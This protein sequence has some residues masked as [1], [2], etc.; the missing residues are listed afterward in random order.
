[1]KLTAEQQALVTDN[2]NFAYYLAHKWANQ[3]RVIDRDDTTCI[4]C[5]ALCRAALLFDPDRGCGFLTFAR[6]HINHTLTKAVRDKLV[7]DKIESNVAH[8]QKARLQ[9][10]AEKE[11]IGSS[12]TDRELRQA[13]EELPPRRKAI[14]IDYSF[15]RLS[16][17]EIALKYGLT[18]A[19]VKFALREARKTIRQKVA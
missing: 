14:I 3:Q 7:H 17:K 15:N 4:A 12:I 9:E 19:Q 6:R 2:I 18:I 5:E 16:Y 10:Q 1:M 11:W 8:L 13:I